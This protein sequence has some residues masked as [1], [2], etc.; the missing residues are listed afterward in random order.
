MAR[1]RKG[2]AV[3]GIL[4]L[5]KPKGGSSNRAL[6][7]VKGV[8]F[9]Q[10]AGHTGSL[11]PMATGV[12]PICLGEAT[13]FSQFLLNADK[14]YTATI[15]FGELMSTGDAEGELV[16]SS[17]ASH[18][19][20]ENLLAA[21]A[22][23]TGEIKQVPPMYSAL[24]VDGQPLYKLARQGIEIARKARD[25]TIFEY[26]LKAFRPGEKAEADVYVR[27]SKGTY[28][29][30]LAED[31]AAALGVGGHLTALHRVQVGQFHEKD[32]VTQEQLQALRD[33][34]AFAEMDALLIP[35]E[36]AVNHLPLVEVD[37]PSSYYIRL[38]QAVFVPNAPTEGLVRL[39][40]ETG[41]FIGMG[42]V[43]DDGRITP[44]RL[45][46]QHSE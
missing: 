39:K 23:L 5:N 13:K 9:A 15:K 35:A 8:F 24:K 42:E 25:I 1:R 6:Q 19:T 33:K 37:E 22:T 44:R 34:E 36:V 3:D 18:I 11:D 7:Q 38:G 12:L 29:R 41:L 21:I 32:V 16:D 45:I 43:L 14:A 4:L 27:S 40:D 10:K 31:T 28:I 20:E 30:S 26:S 2:R 17:D 46:A